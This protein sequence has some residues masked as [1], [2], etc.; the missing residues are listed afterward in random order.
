MIIQIIGSNDIDNENL[1]KYLAKKYGF[2]IYGIDFFI[3]ETKE[4]VISNYLDFVFKDNDCIV[5]GMMSNLINSSFYKRRYLIWLDK[6]DENKINNK[7][8][9]NYYNEIFK[10]YKICKSNKIIIKADINLRDQ[11]QLLLNIMEK[12]DYEYIQRKNK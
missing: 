7:D 4:E 9:M 3:K 2:E 11:E 6:N 8:K 10:E 5:V 1:G 12:K